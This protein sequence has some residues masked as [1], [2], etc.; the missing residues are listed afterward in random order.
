MFYVDKITTAWGKRGLWIT[1][2]VCNPSPWIKFFSWW[3]TS[4]A[5]SFPSFWQLRWAPSADLIFPARKRGGGDQNWWFHIIQLG[6]IKAGLLIS[7]F[8]LLPNSLQCSAIYYRC[9]SLH[10]NTVQCNPPSS[11]AVQCQPA[12]LPPPLTAVH[13]STFLCTRLCPFAKIHEERSTTTVVQHFSD[14]LTISQN[15]ITSLL[16]LN[17]HCQRH[18]GPGRRLL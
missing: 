4:A 3:L 11:N 13:P 12:T 17:V 18:Y 14:I 16:F 10:C 2:E 1:Y 8:P 7:P 5:S 6:E 15:L 9:I